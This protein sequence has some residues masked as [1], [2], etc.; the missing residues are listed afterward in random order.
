[1]KYLC[2]NT[3]LNLYKFEKSN[4]RWASARTKKTTTIVPLYSTV[5]IDPNNQGFNPNPRPNNNNNNGGF[6]PNPNNNSNGGNWNGNGNS[7][8]NQGFAPVGGKNQGFG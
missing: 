5:S 4:K 2:K 8:S 7:G 6:N 3:Y 1:M